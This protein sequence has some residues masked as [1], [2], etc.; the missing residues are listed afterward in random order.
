[1]ASLPSAMTAHEALS[2]YYLQALMTLQA[3]VLVMD[4]TDGAC[5]SYCQRDENNRTCQKTMKHA[6][7]LLNPWKNVQVEPRGH[8]SMPNLR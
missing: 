4:R 7:Y 5:L 3:G 1:M 2:H 6:T 8:A